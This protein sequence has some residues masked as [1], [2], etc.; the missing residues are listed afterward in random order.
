M[1]ARVYLSALG[2][3]LS[4]DPQEGGND[5]AY[6]YP[7]DPVNQFDLDGNWGWG[8]VWNIAKKVVKVATKVAE[9]ASFIPGPIGMVSSGVAVAGNL[10]Q[11]NYAAAVASAI[12]FIPGGKAVGWL[13][14]KSKVGTSLLGKAMNWQA[15]ARGIGVNSKL[16][17]TKALGKTQGLFNRQGSWIKA[18]WSRDQGRTTYRYGFGKKT[19]YNNKRSK[20]ITV[21]RFHIGW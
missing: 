17:G 12:G 13:A 18:G 2:R 9:V 8:D 16:F 15:K 19:Y 6:T 1:G 14:S 5:N 7:S 20:N 4:I 3:F 11:G 21:S 10:A